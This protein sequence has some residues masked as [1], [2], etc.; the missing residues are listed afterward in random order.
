MKISIGILDFHNF[1][2]CRQFATTMMKLLLCCLLGGTISSCVSFIIPIT[3]SSTSG[4]VI[5]YHGVS[6]KSTTKLSSTNNDNSSTNKSNLKSLLPKQKR[7]TI[8]L[9]KYGRRIHDLK[10]D[11]MPKY[12]VSGSSNSS[13]EKEADIGIST[14]GEKEDMAAPMLR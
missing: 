5:K 4:G 11:G 6:T 1:Q 10:S 9:D 2:Q 3:T 12:S 7:Q 8:P 13:G 14:Y